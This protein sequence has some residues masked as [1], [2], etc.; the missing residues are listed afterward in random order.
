MTTGSDG[1]IVAAPAWHKFM[2]GAL[3]GV[4]D[5]WYTAPGDVKMGSDGSYFLVSNPNKIDHLPGDDPSPTPSPG[6]NQFGIPPDPGRGPQPVD[7]RVCKLP[8]PITGCPPQP[9]PG[10]PPTP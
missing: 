6:T 5:T 7:P 3:K 2:E 4:P 1:V 10:V 9:S 8:L